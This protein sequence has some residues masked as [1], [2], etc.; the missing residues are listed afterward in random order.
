MT[1]HGFPRETAYR[2][3]PL[4]LKGVAR[5]W[6]GALW[7][8]TIEN[9]EELGRQF[10][11]QFMAN[12]WRRRSAAYLL[13]V[14][15]KDDESLKA[16]LVRFNKERMTANDQDEKFMMA[17]LLGGIWPRSPFM[18]ELARKT[19]ST[20]IEFMDWADD[21]VNAKETLIALTTRSG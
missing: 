12:K 11:T 10:I 13:T 19:P 20:L 2:A 8:D 9:F 6:F 18:T 14:K 5:G 3:F 15:Q 16:Y 21:F 1:L 4:T 7:S 17:A